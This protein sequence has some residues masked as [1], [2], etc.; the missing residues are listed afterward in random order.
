MFRV[1]HTIHHDHDLG[2]VILAA[3][4]CIFGSWVV[5][6]LYKHVLEQPRRQALIWCYLTAMTAGITVWCTHFIAILAYQ[7]D[8]PATFH[9]S[10]TFLSLIIAIIGSTLGVLIAGLVKSRRAT[11]LGGAI[12]GLAIA[13]MHY[14]GM[15]AYRVQ[16][17]IHWDIQYLVASV[18]ISVVLT[19]LALGAARRGGRRS[20][21]SM[22]GL[23]ALAI[24][25]LHF[26][27][28]AAFQV[29]PLPALPDYANPVEYRLI[30]LIIAGTATVI[31]LAAFFS[32]VVE[33][34]T[35]SESVEE[36]R[37]ARDAAESA[38][39]AKSE[40]MSVLS[41]ELRTP[42]TIVIGYAS[43]LSELKNH[44][45]AKLAPEEKPAPPHFEKMGDQAQLY[46]QR[47][48]FAGGQLLTIIN[49]I[50]DYTNMELNELAL[51]KTLFDTRALL[52]EVVEEHHG[53][54]HDKTATLHIDTPVLS[55]T[56]DRRRSLQLLGHIVGNALK[57]SKARDIYL[58]VRLQSGG[59]CFEVEDN[60][61]GIAAEDLD[62]IFEAFTQIEDADDRAEGGTGLGLAICKKL[63]LAHGGDITVKSTLGQGTTFSV[64]IPGA[65]QMAEPAMLAQAS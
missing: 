65:T 26:T 62:R 54:A 59:F 23:L 51:D 55:V 21:L 50:L 1:A 61:V 33:N 11:I 4:L 47:I 42:L 31:A 36:L 12:F 63:A 10:L 20:V 32:Y 52:E 40:F 45:L 24:I 64:F 25:L 22:A 16:G 3:L 19:T 56:A 18:I 44:N 35:R 38:S 30:A 2:L 53:S 29:T 58:R 37:K 27:G 41:H 49:D 9:F 15:V 46:G 28:M 7:L 43:F 39:R 57:F 8:A 6:R 5:S 48:K 17:T 14:T 34:R 60:G 13:A